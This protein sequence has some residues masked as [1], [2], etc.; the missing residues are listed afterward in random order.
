MC[1]LPYCPRMSRIETFVSPGA[2]SAVVS[3]R[4]VLQALSATFLASQLAGVSGGVL[5]PTHAVVTDWQPP[6]AYDRIVGLL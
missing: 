6:P 5:A 4:G 1:L 2:T 3:R